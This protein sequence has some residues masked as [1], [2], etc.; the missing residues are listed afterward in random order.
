MAYYGSYAPQVMY[1]KKEDVLD[2][3][4]RQNKTT[5]IMM[6][7]LPVIL[8][9]SQL[10]P[11]FI[12]TD[13]HFPSVFPFGFAFEILTFVGSI[14]LG[15]V[16]VDTKRDYSSLKLKLNDYEAKEMIS[17]KDLKPW[18]QNGKSALLIVVFI[19]LIMVAA[20]WGMFSLY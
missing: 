4:E 12:I 19:V 9:I 3:V 10:I 13:Y 16:M 14:I 17:I 7:F 6:I 20:L 8:F 5:G 18:F 15:I 2:Y 11:L 1:V